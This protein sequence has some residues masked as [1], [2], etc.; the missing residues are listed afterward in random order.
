MVSKLLSICVPNFNQGEALLQNVSNLQLI[1]HLSAVEILISDNGST[2]KES[3]DALEI[4]ALKIPKAK[5]FDGAAESGLKDQWFSGFGANIDRLVS[6][7]SGKYVWIVG[8]GDL[9]NLRYMDSILE[10]LAIERFQNLTLNANVHSN[11]LDSQLDDFNSLNVSGSSSIRFTENYS[12]KFPYFDLSISC[13]IT[14][15][16]ILKT[17]NEHFCYQD[18]WPH[19][20]KYLHY[21]SKN[22]SFITCKLTPP[23]LLV[24]QPINGWY[25]KA[26]AIDTLLSLG[27][28]YY[29]YARSDNKILRNIH[30]EFFHEN[31]LK[32]VAMIIHLRILGGKSST[33]TQSKLSQLSAMLP[34]LKR[35]YLHLA[36]RLPPITLRLLRLLN[37]MLVGF[38]SA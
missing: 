5:I 20:E 33:F 8:S 30:R 15:R 6:N 37:S 32:V 27:L 4:A 10:L 18:S 24:H 2:E 31:I 9:I 34:F 7:A 25:T 19:V 35:T 21:I 29:D 38:R 14:Q 23:L 16:H 12:G 13:N 11:F 26:S 3:L 28:L 17:Y 36:L 22:T 1:S